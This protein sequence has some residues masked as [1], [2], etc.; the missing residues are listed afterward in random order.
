MPGAGVDRAPLERELRTGQ[1]DTAAS[2]ILEVRAGTYEGR[3]LIEGRKVLPERPS[4]SA[5]SRPLHPA[6]LA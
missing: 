6:P 3:Y 5:S 2:G 1:A 4:L